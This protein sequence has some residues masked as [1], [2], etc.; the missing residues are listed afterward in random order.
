M[1]G[2]AIVLTL[3]LVGSAT[4]N[5][6]LV[7]RLKTARPAASLAATD[8]APRSGGAAPSTPSAPAS[9]DRS[10]QILAEL[11]NL[12]AEVADLKSR[13]SGAGPA[14][15]AVGD[16]ART[17]GAPGRTTN[18]KLAGIL[19]EQEKM[20]S[21]WK[22]VGK[23]SRAKKSL[24]PEEFKS[25]MIDLAADFLGLQGGARTNFQQAALTAA[26]E[27]ERA[28]KEYTEAMSQ[29]KYD[30]KNPQ[31]YNQAYQELWKRYSEAQK[32]ANA[33][34]VSAIPQDQAHQKGFASSLSRFTG[35]FGMYGGYSVA[36]SG[37]M[38]DMMD[39]VPFGD[40]GDE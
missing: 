32:N 4:A 20:S 15:M 38:G 1:K 39:V 9:S 40:G 27:M 14:P 6:V 31:A 12:R 17:D 29:I 19:A 10:D 28:T 5:V 35:V 18:P 23:V 36:F 26:A 24:K 34:L 22:D 33:A 37:D 3:A 7:Q 25:T 8:P 16:G 11:T 2:A 30:E 13:I 21:F